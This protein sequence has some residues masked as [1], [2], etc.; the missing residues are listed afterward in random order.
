MIGITS[1]PR[2]LSEAVNSVEYLF[3]QLNSMKV[4]YDKCLCEKLIK[5]DN[6]SLYQISPA[7][8]SMAIYRSFNM[9]HSEKENPASK[10]H[11]IGIE[12]CIGRSEKLNMNFIHNLILEVKRNPFVKDAIPSEPITSILIDI[13]KNT[14]LVNECLVIGSFTY[15]GIKNL[16]FSSVFHVKQEFDSTVS[17]ITFSSKE[18]LEIHVSIPNKVKII[19]AL[20]EDKNAAFM[21]IEYKNSSLDT[22]SLSAIPVFD[23]LFL[24]NENFKL[25]S[26]ISPSQSKKLDPSSLNIKTKTF[27]KKK[28]FITP[29]DKIIN[30]FKTLITETAKGNTKIKGNTEINNTFALNPEIKYDSGVHDP[31][32]FFLKTILQDIRHVQRINRPS[33]SKMNGVIIEDSLIAHKRAVMQKINEIQYTFSCLKAIAVVLFRE[34][35]EYNMTKSADEASLDWKFMNYLISDTIEFNEDLTTSAPVSSTSHL[36]CNV[37]KLANLITHLY[38]KKTWNHPP[39]DNLTSASRGEPGFTPTESRFGSLLVPYFLKQMS[40]VVLTNNTEYTTLKPRQ[41]EKKKVVIK[42]SSSE[43]RWESTRRRWI[44]TH[45]FESYGRFFIDIGALFTPSV[46]KFTT[47]NPHYRNVKNLPEKTTVSVPV[48]Y[49]MTV[50]LDLQVFHQ[51]LHPVRT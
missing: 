12:T 10:S 3:L 21:R 11:L 50:E 48:D 45:H 1:K 25:V 2:T 20:N 13:L 24:F 44:S 39:H 29:N 35:Y 18:F 38:N 8:G 5:C 16:S 40:D 43:K 6:P 37:A 34:I 26:S 32:V 27:T 7:S 22:S 23:V 31:V 14:P 49:Q 9:N 41:C 33:S 46:Y 36:I 19:I 17:L 15:Y 42:H 51:D 28:K 4:Y 30:N 47:E